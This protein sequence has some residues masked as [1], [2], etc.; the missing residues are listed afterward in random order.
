MT[1]AFNAVSNKLYSDPTNIIVINSKQTADDSYNLALTES[2]LSQTN[3][4]SLQTDLEE[5]KLYLIQIKSMQ[6]QISAHIQKL[7]ATVSQLTI[8]QNLASITSKE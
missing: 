6:N 4:D 1:N 3:L 5:A 7:E 2:S 8:N